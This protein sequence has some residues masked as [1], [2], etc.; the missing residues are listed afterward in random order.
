M[1]RTEE[2]EE[3]KYEKWSIDDEQEKKSFVRSLV[4]ERLLGSGASSAYEFEM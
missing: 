4:R 2:R 3:E 1:G